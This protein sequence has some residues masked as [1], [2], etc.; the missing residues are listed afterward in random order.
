MTKT[1]YMSG[2]ARAFMRSMGKGMGDADKIDTVNVPVTMFDRSELDYDACN[3]PMISCLVAPCPQI[4]VPD[5]CA[6]VN[7]PLPSS[8]GY[9]KPV[10]VMTPQPTR[11]PLDPNM[12]APMGGG[13]LVG[14]AL[15]IGGGYYAWKKLK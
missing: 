8:V 9:D 5:Y 6:R 15:L 7:A 1:G 11:V 14:L 13:K 2:G 10:D 12:A 3:P 4:P